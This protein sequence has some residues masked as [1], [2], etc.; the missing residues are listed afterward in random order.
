M[1]L[2]GYQ[3]SDYFSNQVDATNI[4]VAMVTKT[5]AIY[6]VAKVDFRM[7]ISIHLSPPEVF[8]GFEL[9]LLVNFSS[10]LHFRFKILA[11][12]TLLPLGVFSD[13]SWG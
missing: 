4:L 13:P 5:I 10:G 7:K 9:P 12:K 8:S 3:L 6:R 11:F 2:S 1:I